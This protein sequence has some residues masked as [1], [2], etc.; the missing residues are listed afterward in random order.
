MEYKELG[1]N[2]LRPIKD[3]VKGT[4]PASGIIWR[5]DIENSMMAPI[6]QWPE[7]WKL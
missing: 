3:P 7:A 6:P 1:L 5:L 2:H 4:N